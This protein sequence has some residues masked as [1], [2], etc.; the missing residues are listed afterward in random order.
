[1]NFG[2]V[3]LIVICALLILL[4]RG[5]L[6]AENKAANAWS[7]YMEGEFDRVEYGYYEYTTRHGSMVHS[8]SYHKMEVTAFYLTDGRCCTARGRYDMTLP[9]GTRIKVWRNELGHIR[10]RKVEA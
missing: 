10:I 4:L 7:V 2:L 3:G 1:M 8:T 5:I 6:K 9:R